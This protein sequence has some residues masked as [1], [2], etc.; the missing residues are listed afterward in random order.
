LPF[1]HF[2]ALGKV[3]VDLDDTE[4]GQALQLAEVGLAVAVRC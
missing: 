4:V 3:E 2:A 1:V